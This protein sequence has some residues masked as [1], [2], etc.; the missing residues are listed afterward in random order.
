M[1]PPANDWAAWAYRAGMA[2]IST[3]AM[4][5]LALIT[6]RVMHPKDWPAAAL[7]KL[8]ELL[9]W[10]VLGLLALLVVQQVGLVARNLV[11]NWNLKAGRDGLEMQ[12]QAH[13]GEGGQ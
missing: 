3:F 4:V 12:V 9:G 6:W 1:K 11:R 2:V 8:L 7:P 10:T 5:M 13:D